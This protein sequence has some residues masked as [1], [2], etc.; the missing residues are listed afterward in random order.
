MF[1]L[2]F[3]FPAGRYHATPWGRHVNEAAIAWPPEPWRLLRA[4]IAVWTRKGDC[5]RWSE[6]D[7]AALIDR[8]A[9]MPPV[10]RLPAGAVHTHTRHYMPVGRIKNGREKTTLVF[11][12]FLRLPADAEL[13][14]AW[15]S[16][17]LPP[18]LFNLA[19]D[20]AAGLL[21]LG[22]TE[23]WVDCRALDTW[24]GEANCTPVL[25]NGDPVPVIAPL[26]PDAYAD[27]RTRLIAE[28]EASVLA[29]AESK[30][31]RA[32]SG[33]ALV[34]ARDRRLGGTLP[35][36][37]VD[38]LTLDTADY[39][40]TGWSRPPASR[41]LLYRRA[42]AAAPVTIAPERG[43]NALDEGRD[44]TLARFLLAGRP[45]PAIT[46]A[47]K[48]G[49]LMRS[50]TLARFGWSDDPDTGRRRPNAPPEI[51]GR[52]KRGVV[53]REPGHAHAFW[54]PEDADNDGFIDHVNVWLPKGIGADLREQLDGVTRL[55]TKDREIAQEQGRREWRL[56]LEGFG[57]PEEF[58][59]SSRLFG[60]A[61]V[62]ESATVF[63]SSGGIDHRGYAREVRRLLRRR[64]LVTPDMASQVKVEELDCLS[65]GGSQ[66]R[67]LHFFRFRSR[68]REAQPDAT[69]TLL[70]L[71]FPKP[72]AGP[73]ALGYG[74]HFGLGIFRR[75]DRD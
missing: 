55:W 60:T 64:A 10:Y 6:R 46:D 52:D 73:L 17:T 11:D 23:S 5:E 54:L 29:E 43:G 37:L 30:G 50:A 66:H 19:A 47:V 22:R 58:G 26:A 25:E 44:P 1:A 14:A 42:C 41:E 31:K 45:R 35:E 18:D 68:G 71:T 74:S 32:P 24:T 59:G 13:I 36:R 40:R 7:L 21:Y 2:S 63:L 49:E 61:T 39:Q 67:P 75:A 53:M 65:I 28:A 62:W 51:S 72:L 69:G 12:A 9:E 38:A 15:P 70:R 57:E 8:L 20:L 34:K 48:I 27:E 33:T 4:L 16:L 3:T 56:A